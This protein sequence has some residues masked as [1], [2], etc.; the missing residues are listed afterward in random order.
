VDDAATHKAFIDAIAENPDDDTARL[1]YADWL[2]ERGDPR[3][4]YLRLEVELAVVT[5]IWQEAVESRIVELR[6]SLDPTWI[7]GLSYAIILVDCQRSKMIPGI[8][9]IRKEAGLGLGEAKALVERIPW[10]VWTDLA[11]HEA[12]R[13]WNR[14]RV[15]HAGVLT[16]EAKFNG[17]RVAV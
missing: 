14:L 3:A 12:R 4:E 13:L 15:E 5:T 9:A 1:V 2:D 10:P 6:A 8:K 17:W 7:R 11:R 16:F